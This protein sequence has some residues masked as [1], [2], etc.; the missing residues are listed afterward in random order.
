MCRRRL[1]GGL[2]LGFRPRRGEREGSS[3]W[4][5]WGKRREAGS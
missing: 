3:D 2:I 5:G 4:M 1:R